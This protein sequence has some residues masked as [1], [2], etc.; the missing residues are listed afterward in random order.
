MADL[1]QCHRELTA[2]ELTFFQ[3]T[4]QQITQESVEVLG[5]KDQKYNCISYSLVC[6]IHGLMYD[7][8]S[9]A[10]LRCICYIVASLGSFCYPCLDAHYFYE[11][12]TTAEGTIDAYVVGAIPIHAAKLESASTASSKIQVHAAL[13]H[14]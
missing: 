5:L 10:W 6:P 9:Q 4:C 3:K 7:L 2:G 12:C 11:G 8:L 14:P 1:N 13:R